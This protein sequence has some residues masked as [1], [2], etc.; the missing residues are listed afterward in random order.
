MH[1]SLLRFVLCWWFHYHYFHIYIISQA[2]LVRASSRAPGLSCDSTTVGEETPKGMGKIYRC[3]TKTKHTKAQTICAFPK[4]IEDYNDVIMGRIASQTT[5]LTIVYSTVYS[6]ADQRKHQSSA[7]LAFVRGI[8]RWIP[9][10]NDQYVF[11]S[12][13]NNFTAMQF[14]INP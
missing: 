8:H 3:L 5:S 11:F 4:I 12:L 14:T 6:V 1:K 9:R 13:R 10:T 2:L 7:S